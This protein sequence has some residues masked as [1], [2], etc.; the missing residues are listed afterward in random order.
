MDSW[1]NDIDSGKRMYSEKPPSQCRF[2]YHKA[3]KNWLRTETE[4]FYTAGPEYIYISYVYWTVHHLDIWIKVHQLADTCFIMS[5]YCYWTTTSSGTACTR[6]PHHQQPIPLHNTN[7]TQVSTIQ[8]LFK[9]ASMWGDAVETSV[10]V[11]VTVKLIGI[12]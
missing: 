5:V 7:T 3:Q 2:V 1:W 6:I 4:L 9:R 11:F 10:A 12:F 8:P